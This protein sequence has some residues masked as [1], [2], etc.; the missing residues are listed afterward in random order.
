MPLAQ[1]TSDAALG[2]K[3]ARSCEADWWHDLRFE[4]WTALS[5]ADTALISQATVRVLVD[6]YDYPVI[7]DDIF[8]KYLFCSVQ[9]VAAR[10]VA[11]PLLL[12]GKGYPFLSYRRSPDV[13]LTDESRVSISVTFPDTISVNFTLIMKMGKWRFCTN[14]ADDCL[15]KVGIYDP[16]TDEVSRVKPFVPV[17]LVTPKEQTC[18]PDYAAVINKVDGEAIVVKSCGNVDEFVAGTVSTGAGGGFA[19]FAGA[20]GSSAEMIAA[21]DASP[22][23]DSR[24]ILIPVAESVGNVSS[25]R[26]GNPFTKTFYGSFIP[27]YDRGSRVLPAFPSLPRL[28]V[29]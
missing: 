13:F 4:I 27:G 20:A 9:Q 5:I 16:N 3:P 26:F 15:L 24:G 12:A 23:R 28:R 14:P 25:G 21:N 19:Q 1:I 18:A 10:P 11:A 2:N 7:D 29:V 6:R 22:L 8:T 17:G